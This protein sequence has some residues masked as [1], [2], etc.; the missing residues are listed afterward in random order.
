MAKPFKGV[1]SRWCDVGGRI[2]GEASYHVDAVGVREALFSPDPG[3]IAEDYEMMTSEI[4]KM[5]K[6]SKF[7]ICETRNSIYVLLGDPLKR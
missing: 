6:R 4:V 2:V 7:T 1:I 3:K 5:E